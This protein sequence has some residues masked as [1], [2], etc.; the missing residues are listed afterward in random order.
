MALREIVN[1]PV[2]NKAD[3][4]EVCD[5]EFATGLLPLSM[6]APFVRAQ[7]QLGREDNLRLVCRKRTSNAHILLPVKGVGIPLRGCGILTSMRA[8]VLES[9]C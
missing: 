6:S 7:W 9:Y 5:C 1:H 4:V 8:I 2:L 3:V